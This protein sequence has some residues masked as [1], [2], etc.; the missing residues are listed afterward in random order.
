MPTQPTADGV[1]KT[2]RLFHFPPAQVFATF[3]DADRLATWWGPDGSSNTFELF[4]F[5][6]R[7]RWKFVMHEPDCTH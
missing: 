6:Q 3:A 7:G 1:F 5:K 2:G 4:E